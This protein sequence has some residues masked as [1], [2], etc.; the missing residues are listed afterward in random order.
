VLEPVPA[1]VLGW[2][3]EPERRREVDD[4]TDVL[5]QLRHGAEGGF[6][7]KSEEHRVEAGGAD[8][9]DIEGGEL[10]VRKGHGERR[11]ELRRQHADVRVGSGDRQL[12]VWMRGDQ[13]EQ[14]DAGVSGCAD[15][16]YSNHD[17]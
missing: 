7:G 8:L 12:E 6:V 13:T 2:I 1:R 9:V 5:D 15:D 11:S 3:S 17:A 4:A 14:L 16:A 10:E